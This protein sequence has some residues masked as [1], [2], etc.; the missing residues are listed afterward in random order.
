MADICQGYYLWSGWSSWSSQVTEVINDKLASGRDNFYGY[1]IWNEHHGSWDTLNGDFYTTLWKPTYDLIRSLDPYAKIIG[2]SDSYYS[3]TRIQDFLT[4][5]QNNNCLPDIICWH[6]LQGSANVSSHI[7]SYRSL[8]KNLRISP[9]EISINEYSSST[10]EYEGAP[11]VSASFIAKFERKLVNS[12]SISWWFTNLPGKLGSLLTA[13]NE[14]GGGWLFYKWYG[15]MTGYMANVTPPN[16]ISDGIDGFACLNTTR[17]YAS[18]C[19]GG[20]DSGMVDV[21]INGIPSSFGDSVD[22]KVEYVPWE[23]KDTPVPGPI[24]VSLTTYVVSSGTFTV[25]VEVTD[26]LYGYRVLIRPVGIP[27]DVEPTRNMVPHDYAL[28]QNYPNPFNP[29]TTIDYQISK[30]S[31]V[32]LKVYDSL[33]REVATLVNKQISPGK[34]SVKFDGSNLSSG[35]YFYRLHTGLFVKTKKLFLLK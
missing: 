2:P 15:D 3:S 19:L 29:T 4:F 10:H 1:E 14:K 28:S 17:Q 16:E 8:E 24:T 13:D 18:I 33:G 26:P 25:P 23:N 21:A 27:D 9:L 11:G 34:Y 5:C 35:I 31:F 30:N 32:T 6:E 20:N 7:D 22:V 12:A